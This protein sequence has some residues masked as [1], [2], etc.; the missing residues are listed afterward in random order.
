[1][2]KMN[3]KNIMKIVMFHFF[4]NEKLFQYLIETLVF[5]YLWQLNVFLYQNEYYDYF[6]CDA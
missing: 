1:M 4:I 6:L 5:V 2:L 3:I